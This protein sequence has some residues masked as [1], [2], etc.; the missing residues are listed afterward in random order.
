MLDQNGMG[1]GEIHTAAAAG[2]LATLKRLCGC[3]S[4]SGSKWLVWDEILKG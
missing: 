1:D 4:T 3:R 2:D